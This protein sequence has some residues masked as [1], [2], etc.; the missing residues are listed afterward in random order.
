M[1]GSYPCWNIDMYSMINF[2]DQGYERF[3]PSD[4]YVTPSFYLATRVTSLLLAAVFDGRRIDTVKPVFK[5]TLEIW[6][7]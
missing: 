2:D 6:V 7:T 3:R 4:R 5:T 1:A